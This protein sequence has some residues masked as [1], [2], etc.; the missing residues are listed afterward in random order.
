MY[1][2]YIFRVK[3]IKGL[4]VVDASVMPIVPSGNT[5]VP[6]IMVAEKASDII[7]ASINCCKW[8]N[9]GRFR[10]HTRCISTD[11]LYLLVHFNVLEGKV[12]PNPKDRSKV[13]PWNN[14]IPKNSA[15]DEK[16]IQ[17]I[18]QEK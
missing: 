5:N 11:E 15:S 14:E 9:S 13:T 18:P 6:T 17:S 4:R 3:N 10:E 1:L 8:A 2:Y 16:M 7:K 12:P